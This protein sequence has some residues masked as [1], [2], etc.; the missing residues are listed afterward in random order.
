MV[1][2]LFMVPTEFNNTIPDLIVRISPELIVKDDTLHVLSVP[3][4]SLPAHVPP[5]AIHDN[6]SE[7][8]LLVACAS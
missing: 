7:M 8:V 1:P 6:P 3:P 4:H 5:I 2:W